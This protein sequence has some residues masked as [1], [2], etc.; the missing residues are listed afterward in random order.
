MY[1]TEHLFISKE[2]YML[3]ISNQGKKV[4]YT[5][6]DNQGHLVDGGILENEK[7]TFNTDSVFKEI[8]SSFKE[9]ITF[10]EPY[11]QLMGD[12]ANE[13]LEYI[14]NEEYINM[15]KKVSDFMSSFEGKDSIENDEEELEK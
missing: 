3:H 8:I 2:R 9:Q 10:S 11:K 4:D 12:E 14:E 7:E 1:N 15:Q 5:F 13:I 6:Y